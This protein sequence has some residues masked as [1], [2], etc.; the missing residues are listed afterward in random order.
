MEEKNEAVQ[1]AEVK[2]EVVNQ[3]KEM[4]PEPVI[5]DYTDVYQFSDLF[6]EHLKV[7]LKDMPH[8]RAIQYI[9]YAENNKDGISLVDLNGFIKKLDMIEYGYI[10]ALMSNIKSEAGQKQYFILKQQRNG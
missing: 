10:H 7:C 5:M 6:I 4:Q 3:V 8:F 9:E 2:E 1:Q